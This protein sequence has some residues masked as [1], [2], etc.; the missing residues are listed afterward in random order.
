MYVYGL[1]GRLEGCAL[2]ALQT[3]DSSMAERVLRGRGFELV[4]QED[5]A[6]ATDA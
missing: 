3:D 5:L 6:D 2:V 4:H 1:L